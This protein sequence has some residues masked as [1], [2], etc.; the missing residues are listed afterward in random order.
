MVGAGGAEINSSYADCDIVAT[1][2]IGYNIGGLVGSWTHPSLTNAYYNFEEVT[3]DGEHRIGKGAI[4]NELATAWIEND[5]SL[6][7]DDYFEQDND[8]YYRIEDVE[9][10]KAMMFF[11]Q[12]T[13]YSYR[14]Y[15]DINLEEYPGIHIPVFTGIFDGNGHSIHNA[16]ID[17]PYNIGIGF[18]EYLCDAT[19]S[20]LNL[21]SIIASGYG[22]TGGLSGYCGWTTIE[23]C[24][25][26]GTITGNNNFVAGMQDGWNFQIYPAL[27]SAVSSPAITGWAVLSGR[28]KAA[29]FR[30][31]VLKE[32]WQPATSYA[33]GSQAISGKAF[34]V[35]PIYLPKL[36]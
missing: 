6:D 30:L 10:L 23:N 9:D 24:C 18:F 12:H 28:V 35:T 8:G 26:D 19:I 16:S 36:L 13:A 25:I 27:C 22:Y 17:M 29:I 1:E 31:V 14:L 11:G 5:Y 32:P 7:I 21:D 2:D 34:Y 20:N 3:I 4:T 15:G 33:G